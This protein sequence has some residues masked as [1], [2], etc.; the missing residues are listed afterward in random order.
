MRRGEAY[1]FSMF[2][3][4]ADEQLREEQASVTQDNVLAM[5]E[6][7]GK[8]RKKV[9]VHKH[10]IRVIAF[11]IG[12]VVMLG[13][14]SSFVYGQVQLSE[15][16]V[17]ISQA[18]TALGEQKSLYTQLQMKNDARQSLST[19]ETAATQK[20]SMRKI[21]SSQMETVEMNSADKAQVLQKTNDD[22]LTRLWNRI[23]E[24]L[25]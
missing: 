8:K 17:K 2:E 7:P 14:M 3:E 19:V 1:D 10:P 20:L 11:G 6:E 16:A 23:C 13:V 21:D 9:R 24:L 5:P 12:L 18:D 22:F 4:H 25:S 15:L